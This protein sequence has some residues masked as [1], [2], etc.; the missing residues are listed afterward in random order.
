MI[1]IRTQN[2][3]KII[4]CNIVEIEKVEN[5]YLVLTSSVDNQSTS[6]I[7]GNYNTKK[8]ALLVLDEIQKIIIDGIETY[9]TN[10][11][12]DSQLNSYGVFYEMPKDKDND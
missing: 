12:Q 9:V 7:L 1:V 10:G 4:K 8:N 3:E 5:K 6:I 11:N 2:K